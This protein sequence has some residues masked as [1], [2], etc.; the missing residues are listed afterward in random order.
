MAKG[1]MEPL[2]ATALLIQ[3]MLARLSECESLS[4][5]YEIAVVHRRTLHGVLLAMQAKLLL[6]EVSA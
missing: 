5:Q 4:A 1:A 6:L 3:L 2:H